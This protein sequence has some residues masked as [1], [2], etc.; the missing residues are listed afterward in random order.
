MRFMPP[1]AAVVLASG[2]AAC[3]NHP[4]LVERASYVDKVDV[5]V[6]PTVNSTTLAEVVRQRMRGQAGRFGRTGAPKDIQVAVTSLH[7]KDPALSLLIGDANH[8]AAHVNVRDAQSGKSHGEFDVTA[9]DNAAING[10]IG[11]AMAAT[12][13]K[14]EVDRALANGLARNVLERVYGTDVSKQVFAQ[15][16]AEPLETSPAVAPAAAPD[17]PKVAPKAAPAKPKEPK[18]AMAEPVAAR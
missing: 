15:P 3:V 4:P 2:L 18:T 6:R 12:Q 11:A 16:Y 14:A 7:Y 8:I 9:M 1:L 13:N 17:A 10:V 5:T